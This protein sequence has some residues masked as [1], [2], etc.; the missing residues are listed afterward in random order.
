[1]PK[2]SHRLHRLHRFSHYADFGRH[3]PP[4]YADPRLLSYLFEAAPCV[5]YHPRDAGGIGR[6]SALRPSSALATRFPWGLRQFSPSG[7]SLRGSPPPGLHF[8]PSC[9]IGL[10]LRG[11]ISG[12]SRGVCR[13]VPKTLRPPKTLIPLGEGLRNRAAYAAQNP[14]NGK[15]CVICVICVRSWGGGEAPPGGLWGRCERGC[16]KKEKGLDAIILR[17]GRICTFAASCYR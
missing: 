13:G 12:A 5:P 16:H 3:A 8:W 6:I 1:M 17:G 2:T 14:C 15:I 10:R 7:A 9:L 11:Y 4:D